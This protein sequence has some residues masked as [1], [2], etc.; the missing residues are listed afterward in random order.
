[1]V[2]YTGGIGYEKH[3]M[4]SAQGAI[5]SSTPRMPLYREKNYKRPYLTTP[6]RMHQDAL[7][8]TGCTGVYLIQVAIQVLEKNEQPQWDI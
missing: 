8:C 5:M 4:Y 3:F 7:G 1:M 2:L 6:D